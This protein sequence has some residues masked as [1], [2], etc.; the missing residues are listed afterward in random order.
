M[1]CFLFLSSCDELQGLS[2]VFIPKNQNIVFREFS[3]KLKLIR[4]F[5]KQAKYSRCIFCNNFAFNHANK[6]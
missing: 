3:K 6:T 4:H 1:L 5:R 2:L